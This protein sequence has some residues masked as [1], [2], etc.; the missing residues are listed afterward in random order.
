M[1]AEFLYDYISSQ[2]LA[3]VSSVNTAGDP[4]SAII[5]I[6]VNKDLE[7]VFDTVV[8]SRKY[9]NLL[10]HTKVSLV[11]GWDNE[12]TVQYEGIA[13]L[14]GE[15]DQQLRE[16]YYA[17][18]PDGRERAATWPGLSYFKVTPHWI[19]YSNFNN[20]QV[21]EELQINH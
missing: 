21:I 13:K 19:R 4:E 9:T 20:P 17:S 12:T 2:K 3:V 16:L 14:L 11:I 5:G 6:A 10:Q 15:S 8:S 7:I 1:T 18:Y